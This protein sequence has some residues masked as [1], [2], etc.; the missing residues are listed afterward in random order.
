MLGFF[1][2]CKLEWKMEIMQM[3]DELD[4]NHKVG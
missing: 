1:E 3:I 2:N 4:L